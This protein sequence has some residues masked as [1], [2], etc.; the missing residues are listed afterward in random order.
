[1][2][3]QAFDIKPGIYDCFVYHWHVE[4]PFIKQTVLAG[5]TVQ[6]ELE[7]TKIHN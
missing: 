6:A 5:L 3:I 7:D 2:Y 1:M 4:V